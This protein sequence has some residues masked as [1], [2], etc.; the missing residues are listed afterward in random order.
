MLDCSLTPAYLA[1]SSSTANNVGKCT[2]L[3]LP[4][5]VVNLKEA[6]YQSRGMYV[7]AV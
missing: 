2:R 6:I 5:E 3:V 4:M 1:L 7:R